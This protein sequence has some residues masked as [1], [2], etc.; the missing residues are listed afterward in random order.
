MTYELQ[1]AP[2]EMEI[3][4]ETGLIEWTIP[5]GAVGSYSPR[6]LVSDGEVRIPDNEVK[7]RLKGLFFGSADF[8]QR[9]NEIH[10]PT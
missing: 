2:P 4:P 3:N 7:K 8:I 10:L 1:E 5:L 6:I 9:M